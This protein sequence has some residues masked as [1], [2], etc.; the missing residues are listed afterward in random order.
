MTDNTTT[1]DR[2]RRRIWIWTGVAV[3]A[4][5]LM[6]AVFAGRFGEDPRLV[7]SP[8]IGEQI[9]AM[10]LNYLEGEGSISFDELK[11]D[12]VVVN[13]W[14]SWC[15][16]CRSEHRFLTTAASNFGSEGVKFVGQLISVCCPHLRWVCTTLVEK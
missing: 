6:V 14:A 9:S 5:G 16:P 4:V 7:D 2:S 3:V 11:G 12:V 1:E 8:L 13:F 15:I 10:Q